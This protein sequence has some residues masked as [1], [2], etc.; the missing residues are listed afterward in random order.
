LSY[1]FIT[2]NLIPIEPLAMEM[3]Q[4]DGLDFDKIKHFKPQ[5]N[6]PKVRFFPRSI[7]FSV[8]R[9]KDSFEEEAFE[10]LGFFC[11]SFFRISG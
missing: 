7:V 4:A 1:L 5:K 2:K 3:A 6:Y 9:E 10:L 8:P 11:K